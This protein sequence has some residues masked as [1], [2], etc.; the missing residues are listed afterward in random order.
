M[1][2]FPGMLVG[3]TIWSTSTKDTSTM[4]NSKY[5]GKWKFADGRDRDDFNV[6]A[7][8]PPS[9]NM[10]PTISFATIREAELLLHKSLDNLT[11]LDASVKINTDIQQSKGIVICANSVFFCCLFMAV[12]CCQWQNPSPAIPWIEFLLTNLYTWITQCL[13][14]DHNRL[15]ITNKHSVPSPKSK[16]TK[17][18]HSTTAPM[19]WPTQQR[20]STSNNAGI[21]SQT[22]Y[23]WTLPSSTTP[24]PTPQFWD[25]VILPTSSPGTHQQLSI[26]I[27][28]PTWPLGTQSPSASGGISNGCRTSTPVWEKQNPPTPTLSMPL[29]MYHWSS[30]LLQPWQCCNN[31]PPLQDL[32]TSL[33]LFTENISSKAWIIKEA[34]KSSPG[35]AL[36]QVQCDSTCLTKP[37]EAIGLI[38][39]YPTSHPTLESCLFCSF[40]WTFPFE[41]PGP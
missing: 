38:P 29:N 6:L 37:R 5:K 36:G 20:P 13:H 16:W 19:P 8:I 28:S 14:L 9:S 18:I 35:K 34:N 41:I 24:Y 40:S 39:I 25:D 11:K 15:S 3:P 10:E 27:T 22:T 33:L 26:P 17:R 12:Q 21:S 1:T 23:I 30:I 31:T 7:L 2:T 4:D 32:F